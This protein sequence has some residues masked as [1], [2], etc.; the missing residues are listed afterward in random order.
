M[1]GLQREAEKNNSNINS[2][3]IFISLK[4]LIHTYEIFL[5]VLSYV[6]NRHIMLFIDVTILKWSKIYI[7]PI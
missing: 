2:H 6:I 4:M 7:T 3:I 1:C 5:S